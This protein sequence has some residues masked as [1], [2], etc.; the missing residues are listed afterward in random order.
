[1]YDAEKNENIYVLDVKESFILIQKF[2]RSATK[3]LQIFKL[4][5][6]VQKVRF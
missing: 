5:N 1:V 3:N 6:P 2:V 4:V